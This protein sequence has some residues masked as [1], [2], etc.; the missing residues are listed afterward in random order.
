M[1]ICVVRW[2]WSFGRGEEM[3]VRRPASVTADGFED[4]FRGAA[5]GAGISHWEDRAERVAATG[6]SV[7][8]PTQVEVALRLVEMAIIAKCVAM[9]DLDFCAGQRPARN[10][11]NLAVHEE[12]FAVPVVAAI[13]EPRESLSLGSA[14]DIERSLDRA[15]RTTDDAFFGVDCVS[16]DVEKA[17]N[18]K[19]GRPEAEFL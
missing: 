16:A 2:R 8:R 14:N 4:A 13:V 1:L 19:P 9:P 12:H 17:L 15:G 11:A 18:A 10:V 7:D 3:N 6:I 5:G